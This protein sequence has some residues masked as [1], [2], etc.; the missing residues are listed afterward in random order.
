[1]KH[2]F[3]AIFS[4]SL[5]LGY[6][7][8]DLYKIKGQKAGPT[9]LI[10]GGIHG[11]EPG[12]YFAASI[13]AQHYKISEG[14]LWVVPN[15]NKESILKYKRGINGDL[16]R[17]FSKVSSIDK[18]LTTVKEIKTLI[19]DQQVDLILNLHDGH[20]FFREK[21]TNTIFNPGAWGQTCVIDQ[22]KLDQNS[23]YGDL[24]C[25]A[26]KVSN[27]LNQH[28]LQ[29]HHSF[30][31]RNTKTKKKK[32]EMQHSL[33]YFAINNNKPAFA[34]ETSKEL[35]TTTQ[36]VY[37][38]LRAIEAFMQIMGIKY[39][40]DFELE[41]E[42]LKNITKSNGKLVINTN[43]SLDLDNLRKNLRY[44]PLQSDRNELL[45]T[46]PL[47]GVIRGNG[48][49]DLYIGHKKVSHLSTSSFPVGN[50][51][52]TFEAVVDGKKKSIHLPSEVKIMSDIVF[53]AP[54][55]YRLNVIGFTDPRYKNELGIKIAGH[56]L[57]KRFSLDRDKRRYRAEFYKERAFC[58]M[59][60]LNY[61]ARNNNETKA[62]LLQH[63][64]YKPL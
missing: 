63:D 1:M 34:I 30:N 47:G 21:Y 25:I 12:G 40:R 64:I 38:Q 49:I 18:D 33:T 7:N 26:Q 51:E 3:L 43:I 62:S 19:L 37:Y 54:K 61:A 5:L 44:F 45:F 31:V 56:S 58:G 52:D 55:G 11:N 50:C 15:T 4:I 6:D 9:L 27:N 29:E 46:H 23:S 13:L 59:V 24:E 14:T 53:H 60:I 22:I 36:K 20:G 41:S 57:L 17:K 2:L 48:F 35:Q 8:F 39:Q 28:L 10:F 16:N 32:N 42:N